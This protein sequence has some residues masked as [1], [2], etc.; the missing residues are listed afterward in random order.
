MT[1][2][3]HEGLGWIDFA[4]QAHRV[5]HRA[6][7]FDGSCWHPLDPSTLLFTGYY[8]QNLHAEP[9]LPYHEYAI[10]D[11]NKWA[12]LARSGKVVGVLSRATN[13]KLER[14]PR[15][16]ALLRP[17]GIQHELRMAFTDSGDAWGAGGMYR[18]AGR[19]DFDA[20]EV[21]LI[22]VLSPLIAEG[23][24]RSMLITATPPKESV[25]S[26]G[27]VIFDRNGELE[28]V[29]ESAAVM[30]ADLVEQGN[31][32]KYPLLVTTLAEL[33]RRDGGPD[34][35]PARARVFTRSGNWLLL[36]GSRLAGGEEGRTAVVIEPARSPEVAPL[37]LAAYG[38]TRRER[39]VTGHCLA[40][41]ST[42]EIASFFLIYP[43][44][45][46]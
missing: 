27:V 36:H 42:K 41:M 45:V 10:A 1:R 46:Q 40:G 39:D 13:G 14:S 16:R 24:R 26:P 11:V 4:Q 19:R 25:Q 3:V 17:R 22:R 15:Y 32:G 38:L 6:V 44:T 21:R 8:A 34:G 37:L 9:R 7:P 30:M 28:S 43:H 33:A 5:L 12:W 18:D 20:D 29:S 35:V 23:M 31:H 2:L